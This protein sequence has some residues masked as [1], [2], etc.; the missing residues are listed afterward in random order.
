MTRTQLLVGLVLGGFAAL[1][2]LACSSGPVP[3]G[4]TG[5]STGAFTGG[6]WACA[7]PDGKATCPL[8]C[9]DGTTGSCEAGR[10][11]CDVK[12]ADAGL[13]CAC[14][15]GQ[16][17]CKIT[18]PDGSAGTCDNGAPSC[19]TGGTGEG[20]ACP[21]GQTTCSID[22]ADGTPGT[23]DNGKILC[24]GTDAGTLQWY[25][26]CGDPVCRPDDAGSCVP[27]S[28]A[29]PAVGSTC[30]TKG[31]TCND[32]TR[33]C[34]VELVCDDHDPKG[35]TGG[36]PISSRKFKENIGYLQADD[37]ARLHDEAMKV[38]LATYNYKNG[39]GTPYETHLGFI[40][41]DQ[42]QSLSVDRGHDRVDLYGYLSMILATT[43][44]QQKEIEELR[45]KVATCKR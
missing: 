7:C 45:Q 3:L 15:N 34:G 20:C 17:T 40:I 25:T 32:C 1:P 39:Y 33:G 10:P 16:T 23:C 38:R 43:Q 35:G 37:L 26:T 12:K 11:Y 4:S 6:G 8:P 9:P 29:C 28:K 24:G 44:V 14:P 19:G 22:C 36:C 13:A 41:E 5:E 21:N 42:P 2:F 18:C 31:Q 30:T 27:D